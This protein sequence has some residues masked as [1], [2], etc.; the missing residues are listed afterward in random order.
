MEGDSQEEDETLRDYWTK[1]KEKKKER[2]EKRRGKISVSGEAVSE[3]Q[4]AQDKH[5]TTLLDSTKLTILTSVNEDKPHTPNNSE[6]IPP[7]TLYDSEDDLLDYNDFVSET[8]SPKPPFQGSQDEDLDM[9]G[10]SSPNQLDT[11]N[12]NLPSPGSSGVQ[13]DLTSIAENTSTAPPQENTLTSESSGNISLAPTQGNNSI[14][15]VDLLNEIVKRARP[16]SPIRD[17]TSDLDLFNL[18]EER[19]RQGIKQ[20]RNEDGSFTISQPIAMSLLL[21]L[22]TEQR[23]KNYFKSANDFHLTQ[24]RT[25]VDSASFAVRIRDEVTANI[26]RHIIDKLKS[27]VEDSQKQIEKFTAT[28]LKRVNEN[29]ARL[30]EQKFHRVDGEFLSRTREEHTAEVLGHKITVLTEHNEELRTERDDLE[31]ANLNAQKLVAKLKEEKASWQNKFLNLLEGNKRPREEDTLEE[32]SSR[33]KH[34]SVGN[35]SGD[36]PRINLSRDHSSTSRGHS[37]SSTS[38]RPDR[39]RA[40]TIIDHPHLSRVVEMDE[41][42]KRSL[43]AEL[44]MSFDPWDPQ[45][46]RGNQRLVTL[47]LWKRE[48]RG[49]QRYVPDYSDHKASIHHTSHGA[50]LKVGLTAFKDFAQLTLNY[51]YQEAVKHLHDDFHKYHIRNYIPRVVGDYWKILNDPK[52][53]CY[54]RCVPVDA[55][56]E[57][58][59]RDT[60][61]FK[62]QALPRYR[63]RPRSPIVKSEKSGRNNSGHNSGSSPDPSTLYT[64]ANEVIVDVSGLD[65]ADY[66]NPRMDHLTLDEHAEVKRIADIV[67]DVRAGNPPKFTQL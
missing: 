4:D 48:V 5:E 11:S 27:P 8:T 19:F 46:S 61:G 39:G 12:S 2:A 34:K 10:V 56:Y 40:D 18:K 35:T 63:A 45:I 25:M 58:V 16:T 13:T 23:S 64:W 42:R 57:E 21:A 32:A 37:S 53:S 49:H 14:L 67:K 54:T 51:S 24:M 65:N 15:T 1:S 62:Y 20:F 44:N 7:S 36:D 55:Y 26:T 66:L 38:T 31:K 30:E 50:N 47:A 33:S 29:E 22:E 3:D 28:I 60:P 52:M 43:R 41:Q 59:L 6:G 9:E 17:H